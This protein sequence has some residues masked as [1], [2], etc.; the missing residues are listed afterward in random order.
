MLKG[1]GLPNVS[2]EKTM[3]SGKEIM[4]NISAPTL[5]YNIESIIVAN[6]KKTFKEDTEVKKYGF[7][8]DREPKEKKLYD[9]FSGVNSVKINCLISLSLPIAGLVTNSLLQ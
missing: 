6:I 4:I 2:I 3:T 7:K 8:F 9:D 1:K 5:N